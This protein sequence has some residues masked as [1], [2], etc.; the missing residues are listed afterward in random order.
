MTWSRRL[1]S[2]LPPRSKPSYGFLSPLQNPSSWPGLNPLDEHSHRQTLLRPEIM[3]PVGVLL[4]YIFYVLVRIRIAKCFLNNSKWFRCIVMLEN[5]HRFC[6]CIHH[7]RNCTVLRNWYEQR[8]RSQNDLDLIATGET[9][10]VCWMGVCFW[11]R[12]C[13][14]VRDWW[15][16]S[17]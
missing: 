16:A 15:W 9:G 14:I 3:L 17:F 12:F 2:P 13:V 5:E 6:L 8:P 7:V 4:F 11:F 10:D 1:Y